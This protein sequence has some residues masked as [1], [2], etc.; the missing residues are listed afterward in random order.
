[1]FLR[2]W[3]RDRLQLEGVAAAEA[4]RAGARSGRR[5][6]EG[7]VSRIV[8]VVYCLC[9]AERGFPSDFRGWWWSSARAC[10]CRETKVCE[11]PGLCVACNCRSCYC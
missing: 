4:E 5:R 6:M 7:V 2:I 8:W 3:D 10:V 9:V 1:M 11:P